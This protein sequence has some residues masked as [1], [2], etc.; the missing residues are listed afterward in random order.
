[1]SVQSLHANPYELPPEPIGQ[2]GVREHVGSAVT[3]MCILAMFACIFLLARSHFVVDTVIYF[4]ADSR[5]VYRSVYGRLM[6]AHRP[7]EDGRQDVLG[8]GYQAQPMPRRISDPWQ[9]GLLK[10]IGLQWSRGSP[11]GPP[12]GT[13][14]WLR[15]K[16]SSLAIAFGAFPLLRALWQRWRSFRQRRR[17]RAI[18]AAIARSLRAAEGASSRPPATL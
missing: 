4:G 9:P 8:W 10:T 12:D 1:V 2:R 6:I 14:W 18:E 16:W 13:A 15:A 7:H 11:G 3:A 5:T 17:E